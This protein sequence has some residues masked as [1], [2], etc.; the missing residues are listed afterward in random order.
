MRHRIYRTIAGVVGETVLDPTNMRNGSSLDEVVVAQV[1]VQGL[2]ERM[3]RSGHPKETWGE[4]WCYVATAIKVNEQV[5][6]QLMR[7]LEARERLEGE[8]LTTILQ[9][10]KNSPT[11]MKVT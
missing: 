6:H 1:I 10:I 2:H 9:Q 4:C 8:L 5:G 3:G 11:T 7:E